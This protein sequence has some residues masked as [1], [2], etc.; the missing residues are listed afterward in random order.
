MAREKLSGLKKKVLPRKTK[1]AL[2]LNPHEHRNSFSLDNRPLSD[3]LS[4]SMNIF[5]T[6]LETDL[7]QFLVDAIH[8]GNKVQVMRVHEVDTQGMVGV[9][10]PMH[11]E[12]LGELKQKIEK[13]LTE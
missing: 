7:G 4:Q 3:S 12:M 9:R 6:I 1:R 8:E 10:I 13:V 2:F 5:R 11:Q